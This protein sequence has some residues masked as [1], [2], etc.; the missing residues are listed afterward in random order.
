MNSNRKIQLTRV[1]TCLCV[2]LFFSAFLLADR[3]PVLYIIG[4][5]TVQNNDGNGINEYWGWGSLLKPYLDTNRIS[6]QNHAKSGTSSRTFQTEGRWEKVLAALKP[7]DYV[8]L[9]FGHNDQAVINDSARAKGSLKGLGEDTAQI[10]NLK[11]KQFEIVHTYG[12]YMRKY[13]SDIKAKGAIPLVCSLVPR[14]KW[15]N[16]KVDK[17]QEYVDWARATATANGAFFI[18]LNNRIATKWEQLGA[19]SVKHFFP[20]DHTHTNSAGASLNAGCVAEGILSLKGFSLA[21]YL[22]K[23]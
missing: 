16:G 4:D 7:G 10:F 8:I 20:G 14:F 5:S 2:V 11:T 13:L 19:D 6:L 22:R 1:L 12:W 18:D 17:E 23:K 21:D 15:K 3:K 9:Q